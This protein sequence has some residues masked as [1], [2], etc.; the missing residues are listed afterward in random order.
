MTDDE[1]PFD[2]SP[3]PAAGLPPEVSPPPD[4]RDRVVARLR[5]GGLLAPGDAV[6][7]G[8]GGGPVTPGGPGLAAGGAAMRRWALTAAAVVLAF[9][10]GRATGSAGVDP[11]PPAA[12]QP[13]WVLMLYEGESMDIGDLGLDEV[14]GEY[15]AWARRA[16][17]AGSLV[18]GEKLAEV[19]FVVDSDGPPTERPLGV[20]PPPGVLTGMFVVEAPT[21]DA[22]VEAARSTPHRAFGGTVLI[23]PIDPT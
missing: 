13:R 18:L 17:E 3:D 2:R 19:E 11:A 9:V 4:L 23:R 7:P 1:H 21:L 8:D 22:A 6:P 15:V 5:E 10:A 12:A 16:A 20:A 14:E